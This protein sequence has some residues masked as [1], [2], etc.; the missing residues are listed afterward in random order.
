M[1]VRLNV[2]HAIGELLDLILCTVALTGG[3]FCFLR[4]PLRRVKRRL[5]L[6]GNVLQLGKVLAVGI[7]RR[8]VAVFAG[9]QAPD[10]GKK[11]LQATVPCDVQP[12][13]AKQVFTA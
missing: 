4:L 13:Y 10:L 8:Y 9:E 12:F 5:P 3:G 6:L 1:S 11:F 2:F 7:L